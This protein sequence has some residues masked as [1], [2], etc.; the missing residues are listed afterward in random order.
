MHE[1]WYILLNSHKIDYEQL[2]RLLLEHEY[3]CMAKH[4]I[5][6][7]NDPRSI[8]SIVALIIEEFGS[9]AVNPKTCINTSRPSA[10]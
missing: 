1:Y 6:K 9:A 5:Q 10:S 4:I 3:R 2:D 7:F 8:S